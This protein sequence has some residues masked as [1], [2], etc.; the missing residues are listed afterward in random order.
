LLP[1]A[2]IQRDGADIALPLI[3]AAGAGERGLRTGKNSNEHEAKPA[4][5]PYAHLM[6]R[7]AS[8]G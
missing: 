8:E 1:L 3:G 4:T 5:H 7:I 2:G 6:P